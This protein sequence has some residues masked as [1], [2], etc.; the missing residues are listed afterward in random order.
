M[1]HMM[2]MLEN[3]DVVRGGKKIKNLLLNKGPEFGEIIIKNIPA[4]AAVGAAIA[5][6][7]AIVCAANQLPEEDNIYESHE[8]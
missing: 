1:K 2:K 7:G 8:N 6:V 4:N 5:F 3:T